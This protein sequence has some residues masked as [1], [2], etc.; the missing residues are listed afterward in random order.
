MF[1]KLYNLAEAANTGKLKG[2][3]QLINERGEA[4]RFPAV[5][6][7]RSLERTAKGEASVFLAFKLPAEELAPGKYRLV[8]ETTESS[9]GRMVTGETGV[10]LQ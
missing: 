10:L 6:L 7:D 3:V 5:D 2:R 9:T 4:N 1:Y 8:V